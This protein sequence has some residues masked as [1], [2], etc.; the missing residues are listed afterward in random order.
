MATPLV[1]D[2]SRFCGGYEP[3]QLVAGVTIP[4]LFVADK[5]GWEIKMR[6]KG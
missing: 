5:G 2:G 6:I 3:T 4:W 1:A